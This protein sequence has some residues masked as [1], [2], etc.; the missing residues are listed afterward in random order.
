MLLSHAHLDHIGGLA[1]LADNRACHQVSSGNG[2][3]LAVS[4]IAPVLDD[5]RAH[6]F[7]ERI[8]PDFSAIPTVEDPVL[9]L[10]TLQPGE[11]SPVGLA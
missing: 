9:R 11:P 10:R 8:W 1:Y 5:M 3:A 6:F 2:Q 7:N 4:S